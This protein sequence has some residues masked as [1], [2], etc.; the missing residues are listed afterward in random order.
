MRRFGSFL[1]L[2]AGDRPLF[3]E[4]NGYRKRIVGIG[5]WRILHAPREVSESWGVFGGTVLYASRGTREEAEAVL[6]DDWPLIAKFGRPRVE[7][8]VAPLRRDQ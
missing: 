3:S 7:R 5:R 8:R 2:G 1:L 4:R 6:T